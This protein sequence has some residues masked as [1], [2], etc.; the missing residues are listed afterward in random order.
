MNKP[1]GVISATE[2]TK[3]ATVL[4][5]IG[6]LAQKRGVFPVGRL[7]IDTHGFLLLTNNGALSH[8]MLSPKKHVEKTYVAKIEG[9]MTQE[10]QVSF[11][12]GITLDDGYE[13]MPAHLEILSIDEGHQTSV[14]QIKIK[15][16]KFHQ[17]KRMVKACRK[18]VVD[19]QRISMGPLHLDESLKLGEFRSLKDSELEV[20][21]I[22]N[23]E[24]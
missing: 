9:I 21:K 7:D 11:E 19:L 22:F 23:V 5:L 12:K 10:D 18:T 4:D 20:L 8:A 24:L 2:D 3:H 17:V 13:C 14:V 6:E 15:E 16:G 1:K